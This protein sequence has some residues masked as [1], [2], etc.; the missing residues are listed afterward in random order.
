MHDYGW[1]GVVVVSTVVVLGHLLGPGAVQSCIRN[2]L[3]MALGCK[4]D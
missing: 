3:K 4:K 1:H 2:A